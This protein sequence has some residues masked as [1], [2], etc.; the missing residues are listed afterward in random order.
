MSGAGTLHDFSTMWLPDIQRARRRGASARKTTRSA[1]TARNA[2]YL[3]EPP[4][5]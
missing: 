1:L 2:S 3:D 4:L 5:P